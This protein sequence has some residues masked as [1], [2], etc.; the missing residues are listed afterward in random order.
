MPQGDPTTGV[1]GSKDVGPDKINTTVRILPNP[2]RHVFLS[3]PPIQR[4][5]H[6]RRAPRRRRIGCCVRVHAF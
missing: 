1:C 3:D 5:T 4:W 6:A 2:A